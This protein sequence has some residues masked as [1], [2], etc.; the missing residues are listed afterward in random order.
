MSLVHHVCRQTT[1]LI[2]LFLISKSNCAF[3]NYPDEEQCIEAQQKLND[4]YYM[5]VSLV[6]RLRKNSVEGAAGANVSTEIATLSLTPQSPRSEGKSADEVGL[7][8]DG[9]DAGHTHGDLEK[10][11]KPSTQT[12]VIVDGSDKSGTRG[13]GY[14]GSGWISASAPVDSSSG[15]TMKSEKYFILKSL[16]LRDLELSVQ[17]GI[18]ATQSHN[19]E[20]LNE[21]YR[22]CDN[23]YLIF[24]ANKSG[25]YFGYAR[26]T[27]EIN[28]DPAAA[29]EFAPTSQ[30]FND[31]DLPKAIPTEATETT[32][33][34]RIVDDSARGTIFWEVQS[35]EADDA[36]DKE[37]EDEE[38]A[39]PTVLPDAADGTDDVS[40]ADNTDG[41]E[42]LGAT[43]ESQTWGKPFKLEWL[44]TTRL[45]FYRTRGLRNPLNGNRE[46]KIARDGT[47]V[48]VT[49]GRKLVSLFHQ[50]AANNSTAGSGGG[51]GNSLTGMPSSSSGSS[52]SGARAP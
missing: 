48:D 51:T 5:S 33:R 32:P 20:T 16:T 22:T 40:G 36:D 3:A 26:M 24:S 37:G 14:D 10:S 50:D 25:E 18:W 15:S 30:S 44:S 21:A 27:S 31:A 6:S 49:I 11:R 35:N 4:S 29:I 46:I 52:L 28:Q 23:V 39:S 41:D 43:G 42:V 45:P 7:R 12:S 13:K 19:E 38:K 47:D 1:G 9:T 2:S 17:T 8:G 34:G